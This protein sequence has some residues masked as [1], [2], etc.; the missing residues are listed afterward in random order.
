MKNYSKDSGVLTINQCLTHQGECDCKKIRF[1]IYNVDLGIREIR[2]CWKYFRFRMESYADYELMK[3]PNL[4][5][6]KT[7]YDIICDEFGG[8]LHEGEC[9]EFCYMPNEFLSY[10][11]YALCKNREYKYST[12]ILD[13]FV[14]YIPFYRGYC[15]KYSAYKIFKY[16]CSQI[17]FDNSKYIGFLA[18][19]I[20]RNYLYTLIENVKN[21]MTKTK[22]NECLKDISRIQAFLDGGS[23][24]H[25]IHAV[26]SVIYH[27]SNL[28]KR[29]K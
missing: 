8:F 1:E 26:D 13:K 25:L 18:S 15:L 14:V 11:K 19:E 21:D 23:A 9:V 4:V 27:Y 3:C 16:V 2:I 24:L 6:A 7:L 29:R 10:Q 17:Q 20:V 12:F 28:K 5:K 22:Y